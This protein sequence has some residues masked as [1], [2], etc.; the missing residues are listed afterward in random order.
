M[1]KRFSGFPQYFEDKLIPPGTA[2]KIDQKS[3]SAVE[4][5][6]RI[7]SSIRHRELQ[8]NPIQGSFDLEHLAAIHKYLFQDVSSVAGMIRDVGMKGH[9]TVFARPEQIESIFLVQIN[10]MKKEMIECE[11]VKQFA[12]ISANMLNHIN[13]AHPFREGNGRSSRIFME[14]LANV[15]GLSYRLENLSAHDQQNWYAACACGFKGDLKPLIQFFGEQIMGKDASETLNLF[16]MQ[17]QQK[18]EPSS[19]EFKQLYN[20]IKNKLRTLPNEDVLEFKSKLLKNI[21][22]PSSGKSNSNEMEL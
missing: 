12:I 11:S 2:D 3:Y 9:G 16:A 19:K 18:E 7:L 5:Q 17:L 15:F 21:L 1:V 13:F 22:E 14:Q 8:T 20:M 10:A 4:K 6:A